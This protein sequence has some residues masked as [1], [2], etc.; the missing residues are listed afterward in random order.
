[1]KRYC[2]NDKPF[3]YAAFSERDAEQAEAVLQ[4][5]GMDGILFW[6]AERCSRAEARRIDAAYSFVVFLSAH[7]VRDENVLRCIEQ[8]VRC[9]KKILCVYLEP[10]PLGGGLELLLNSLQMINKNAFSSEEAFL[11][12]LKSA[13]VF[14]ELQI[15][16]AQKRFAKRRALA[17]VLV[18][19]AA[20][21]T[22]FFAVVVPLL[23]VP[24]V[25]AATGTLSRL[26]FGELSLAEL[27][28]V[29]EL[30]VVGKQSYDQSYYGYYTTEDKNEIFIEGI[31]ECQ[32]VGDISDISDLT[33]LKNVK[34]ITFSC[35]Q[36]TDITPL[37]EL[38]SIERLGLNCNPIRSV[39]G[40]EALQNLE[41]IDISHTE[42]SD[43]TPLTKIP[44]LYS[45]D[46]SDTYVSSIDGIE[47]LPHLIDLRIGANVSDISVLKKLDYS[48]ATWS[49]GFTLFF[50]STY[51]RDYSAL[52]SIPSFK[53]LAIGSRRTDLYLPYLEGKTIRRLILQ[54]SDIRSTDVLRS[55]QDLEEL[56]LPYSDQLVSLEG[57]KVH[58]K[59]TDLWLTECAGVEDY[60]VLLQLPNL[61]QLTIST[62]M[63]E[64]AKA[65]LS[66]AAFEIVVVN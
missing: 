21:V 15:T 39:E 22:V 13:A 43:I 18:P 35:N 16:P 20:A 10:T 57:L 62:D 23:I 55:I 46:V 19:V 4:A 53:E 40:I 59:L 11:E 33:L 7:A 61:E 14:S 9:N 27:A 50:G 47:N 5:I 25:K 1:M 34:T 2:K 29:E 58:S 36:I 12:K 41:S 6:H 60:S 56:E 26:G 3:V 37:F 63:E 31:G 45:I 64:R 48:F 17:S 32:P 44:S 49:G 8:A 24:A 66:G 30:Y 65:Q 28:K 51:I 42:I 52:Q 38:T 54:G